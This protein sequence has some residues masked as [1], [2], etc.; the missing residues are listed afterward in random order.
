M[1]RV[2]V[3]PLR[4]SCCWPSPTRGRSPQRPAVH[5]RVDNGDYSLNVW[6]VDWVARTLPTDPAHLFDANIFYPARLTLA[7]SEPLIL[8][9]ALAIPAVW[10]G[11]PR[12]S[13][14]QPGADRRVR[15]LGL[16][17]C[18]AR[19]PRHGQLDRGHGRGV[20]GRLQRASPGAPRAH[21]GAAPR[22]GAARVPGARP[23][24]R[25]R[26]QAL[27]GAARAPSLALQATA[28]IYLLVFT[29]VGGGVCAWIARLPEWR[30]PART[31]A[32]WTL[33]PVATC[34]LLLLPVLWPY[35]EL[36]RTQGMVRGIGETRRCAATGPTI[37]TRARAFTTRRG[38]IASGTAR[39]RTSPGWS[40]RRWR[41]SG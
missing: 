6:A 16:G 28:S 30:Q 1:T 29:G 25:H 11:V 39:M 15:A 12:R 13:R 26:P 21:P 34:A 35:A 32:V 9:G 8:Q 27:R 40:S 36:A 31:T 24:A 33:W 7:Y 37:C 18:A 5:S 38:A 22:A 19:A 14:L 4:A 41:C 17:V 20:G 3:L 23:A 2:S 10:L